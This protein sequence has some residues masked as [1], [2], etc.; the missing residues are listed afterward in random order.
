[1]RLRLT[2][3]WAGNV[4]DLE[5]YLHESALRVLPRSLE[6]EVPECSLVGDGDF[7]VEVSEVA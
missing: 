6:T 5:L 2:I 3:P 1:M 4:S 7:E